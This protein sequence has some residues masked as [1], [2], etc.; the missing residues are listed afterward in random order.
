MDVAKRLFRW[1]TRGFAELGDHVGMGIGLNTA[2][3]IGHPEFKTNP[4]KVGP[5][6][7]PCFIVVLNNIIISNRSIS[8]TI[9]VV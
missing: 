3:V 6:Y 5:T 8:N 2:K 4:Y 1:K 7:L 9:I